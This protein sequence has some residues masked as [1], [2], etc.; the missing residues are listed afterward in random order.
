MFHPQPTLTGKPG[1]PRSTHCKRGHE[2]DRAEASCVPCRRMRERW[3]YEANSELRAKKC[4]YQSQ[5]RKDFFAK[6]GFHAS[7]AQ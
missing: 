5:W 2:R 7:E 6:N 4:A 1:R 3:K